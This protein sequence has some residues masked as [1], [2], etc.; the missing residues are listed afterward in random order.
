[1]DLAELNGDFVEMTAV[2]LKPMPGKQMTVK[3]PE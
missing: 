3:H 2:N 1:M